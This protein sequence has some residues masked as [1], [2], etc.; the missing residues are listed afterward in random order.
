MLLIMLFLGLVTVPNVSSKPENIRVVSYNWYITNNGYIDIL[1]VV[2]EVQNIGPNTI[3]L[4]G[5][6]GTVHSADE[7][8]QLN[9]YT[10]AWVQYLV[11]Q[12]K[13]PFWMEFNPQSS[14]TGDT[15]WIN[16]AG[17]GKIDIAVVEANTTSK[18]QY[19]DLSITENSRTVEEG[20]FRVRGTI[21]NTG[22]KVATNVRVLGTFYN[23][24]GAVVALGGFTGDELVASSLNPGGT[25]TF[26]FFEWDVNQTEA[27]SHLKISSYSLL[28][29]VAEP[30]LTGTP[31]QPSNNTINPTDTPPSS[32]DPSGSNQNGAAGSTPW[33]IYATVAIIAVFG[34]VGV[35]LLF[36]VRKAKAEKEKKL[37][38]QRSQKASKPK[39]YRK[40]HRR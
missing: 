17:I 8:N 29:Q 2:G 12:Q 26:S 36:R 37:Q 25:V 31:P 24:S 19:P 16:Y 22:T 38:M 7:M 23:A 34:V 28:V 1:V 35:L 15:S 13:A 6:V 14:Q 11:P 27:P 10:R 40:P 4:V 20:F 21:Q 32:E 33:E 30:I 9:S 5:L 3:D 39:E 18:Y